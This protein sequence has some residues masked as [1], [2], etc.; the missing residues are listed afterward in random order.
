MAISED[1]PEPTSWMEKAE[2]CAAQL[3]PG[4]AYTPVIWFGLLLICT[5][6]LFWVAYALV[7]TAKDG[8]TS[9]LTYFTGTR[10]QRSGRG[11][12]YYLKCLLSMFFVL[13]GLLLLTMAA[14]ALMTH[15]KRSSKVMADKPPAQP[16]APGFHIV[17]GDF[18]LLWGAP[19]PVEPEGMEA[20]SLIEAYAGVLLGVLALG[21]LVLQFWQISLQQKEFR[22]TLEINMHEQDLD[23][24]RRS[25]DT[26][27]PE[28]LKKGYRTKAQDYQRLLTHYAS[29]RQ[30]AGE[31]LDVM[32]LNEA[33]NLIKAM[34]ESERHLENLQATLRNRRR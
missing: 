18:Q 22:S 23:R 32:F 3:C 16:K 1:I 13:A 6:L 29:K 31:E 5:V 17:W 30:S 10:Q 25:F 26:I 21:G 14:D 34:K 24:L 9:F 4:F 20:S 15:A 7:R 33:Q 28:G 27:L 12:K 2:A 19:E 8:A 11:F